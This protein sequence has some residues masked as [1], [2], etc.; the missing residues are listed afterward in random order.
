ML[1][2]IIS[3]FNSISKA[4]VFIPPSLKNSVTALGGSLG[5]EYGATA[6]IIGLYLT[7]PLGIIFNNVPLGNSRHLFSFVFGILILQLV[8]GVQFA[9]LL[10]CSST[11]YILLKLLPTN[12]AKV[13]VPLFSLLYTVVGHLFNQYTDYMSYNLDYTAC[14]MVLTIKLYSLAFNL[15]DGKK[16]ADCKKANCEPP[17]ATQKCAKFA[18]EKMPTFIEYFG[19]VF[20]FS[21]ILAG[22]A[23]E[24][25]SYKDAVNMT[26]VN[27]SSSKKSLPSRVGPV[28][29]PLLTSLYCM[30][31]YVILKDK[32]PILSP[33]DPQTALPVFLAMSTTPWVNRFAYQIFALFVNR[34]K[35]YTAWKSAE[36]A[37]NIWY[38]GF[39]GYDEKSGEEKGWERSNNADI[40]LCELR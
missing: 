16:I 9:H 17:R 29:Q 10:F 28:L 1:T 5:L 3:H 4:L 7:Y 38:G 18:L 39:E 8:V 34:H 32:F 21:N 26:F 40:L 20:C 33:T 35:Y 12:T 11:S 15:S 22:P 31:F 23:F 6:Y 14:Q 30:T 13:A 24:F 27:R 37:T 19:Y 25:A 2:S 36:G